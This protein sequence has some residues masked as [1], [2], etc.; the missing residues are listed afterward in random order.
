MSNLEKYAQC[1]LEKEDGNSVIATTSY[2]PEKFAKKGWIVDLKKEDGTWDR[3]WK[4]ISKGNI[5]ENPP[6]WRKL[7]RGHR[8]MTGD[9]LP[10][11]GG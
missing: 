8:K 4:V 6:E 2:L 5:T 1:Y 11:L 7:I 3:G 10:K 9:S